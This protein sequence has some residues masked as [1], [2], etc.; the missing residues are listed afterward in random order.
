MKTAGIIGIVVI[1]VII[2]A[3]GA[4]LLAGHGKTASATSTAKTTSSYV[5]TTASSGYASNITSTITGTNTSSGAAKYGFTEEYNSNVGN[6][7][8]NSTGWSLYIFTADKPYSGNSACSGSC[9]TY[10]PPYIVA[11]NL[12]FSSLPGG[13]N[14]SS[15]GTITRTDGS[16]QLTYEGR[17]LYYFG[18]DKAAGQ[19]NGEG[20]NAFG[21]T[22]YVVTLPKLSIP[23]S[24]S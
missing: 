24:T 23:N 1:I 10:W 20:L 15:F 14:A 2:I 7:L 3:I 8:A 11:G 12:T 16:K 18:G 19:I 4:Y 6:Y 17:P 22:W 9:A 5:T 21:G 13:V